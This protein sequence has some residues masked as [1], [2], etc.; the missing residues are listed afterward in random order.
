[1]A[2]GFG[3]YTAGGQHVESFAQNNAT[4]ACVASSPNEGFYFTAPDEQQQF[5]SHRPLGTTYWD[6]NSCNVN[7]NPV[8]FQWTTD[9]CY[10][11]N[12]WN[13]TPTVATAYTHGVGNV[14][15]ESAA[16]PAR[17]FIFNGQSCWNLL[18]D[19]S[20]VTVVKNNQIEEEEEE[21][22]VVE[23]A[24]AN[25]GTISKSRRR[26][27]AHSVIE[28]RYRSSINERIAELKTLVLGSSARASK[29]TVLRAAIDKLKQLKQLNDSLQAEN[30]QLKA[31]CTCSP[32]SLSMHS[33]DFTQNNF[34]ISV[35]SAEELNSNNSSVSTNSK[36]TLFLLFACVVIVNPFHMVSQIS[37]V[38]VA[39]L[40]KLWNAPLLKSVDISRIR[41]EIIENNILR[42][43]LLSVINGLVV[44]L[45]I[46]KLRFCRRL[47][48]KDPT[49][50]K[51][52]MGD[53]RGREDSPPLPLLSPVMI[54]CLQFK[55]TFAEQLL[56]ILM[57]F[58]HF[59]LLPVNLF[60]LL[61]NVDDEEQNFADV[62]KVH[63][64]NPALLHH[65]T[66]DK[67]H[68]SRSADR[69]RYSSIELALNSVKLAAKV[70]NNLE[71]SIVVNV[72]C[73]AA[74]QIRLLP[75]IGNSLAKLL[76]NRAN[77]EYRNVESDFNVCWLFTPIG[78]KFFFNLNLKDKQFCLLKRALLLNCKE[79]EEY[80]NFVKHSRDE[81]KKKRLF[82]VTMSNQE[83]DY[84]WF[85]SFILFGFGQDHQASLMDERNLLKDIQELATS[86]L[87]EACCKAAIACH[88]GTSSKN[89]ENIVC[90]ILQ[91]CLDVHRSMMNSSVADSLLENITS[92]LAVDWC[93]KA[94]IVS[95][96]MNVH[97][98]VNKNCTNADV[99]GK[100]MFRLLLK[101]KRRFISNLQPFLSRETIRYEAI[102]CLLDGMNP[103][104]VQKLLMKYANVDQ[105]D[106]PWTSTNS[107]GGGGIE[108][109]LFSLG[110]Q[111]WLNS[112]LLSDE[113]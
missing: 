78:K 62:G 53:E 31:C 63:Y 57:T 100:H 35:S 56:Q 6:N 96:E 108:K 24:S 51:V 99:N 81:F 93:L 5:V 2:A 39:P 92:V 61:S 27:C 21:V 38:S 59:I 50:S 73:M 16:V 58:F 111:Q 88:L 12:N 48:L 60:C 1:M 36:F 91:L 101:Q 110:P 34:D 84:F 113:N 105:F 65:F 75:W 69:K 94:L 43:V 46:V 52:K 13:S 89:K 23:A 22:V 29:S 109:W 47:I 37:T 28:R 25:A 87:Q 26:R 41:A 30:E 85:V 45:V 103:I 33:L 7:V 72:Y 112:L 40:G 3:Y 68:L 44:A 11:L 90:E 20:A 32:F 15:D 19:D 106:R 83:T 97:L 55:R 4:V 74:L 95:S 77:Q 14:V 82:G 67:T 102:G 66:D 79:V 10:P 71:K 98:L 42:I 104:F 9:H 17:T 54:R 18:A 70:D 86:A 80:I 107:S 64:S 76:Y 8:E 49:C